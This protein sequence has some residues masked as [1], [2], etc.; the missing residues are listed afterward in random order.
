MK[1]NSVNIPDSTSFKDVKLSNDLS[2]N[3]I[4]IRTIMDNSSDLL[5][6]QLIVSG[7]KCSLVSLEGMVS[8]SMCTELIFRPLA[9]INLAQGSTPEDVFT[10]LQSFNIMSLDRAMSYTFGEL[11]H[12]LMSGFVII[13][14]NGVNSAICLGI[15]GY[16]KRSVSEP[17]TEA[18]LQGSQDGF[19]EVVRTNMSLI[20]RRLK[21]PLLKF[22]LFPL[23]AKSQTDICLVYMT[24]KAPA[25][26]VKQIKGNLSKVDLEII[27]AGGYIEPF[28][29]SNTLS[30]FSGVSTT[31][32]PDVL[33]AKI[34]EG[35]VAVLVDGTPF[36]I[37]VP[38]L[39]IENFQTLD[40]YSNRPFYG[41]YIRWLKYFAVFLAM[42][43]PGLY[44][45][46]ATFHPEM[47]THSLL[48]NLS[49]AQELTPFNLTIE[50]VIVILLYE[51]IREAGIRMPKV[52]GSAVGIVGGLVIGDAAVSSGLI[53]TPLL[54]IL[55]LTATSSFV[56]PNL[57]QQVSVL[58]F[59]FIFAGGYLGLYG[60]A[61]LT[62]LVLF[63]ICSMETFG[64]P[65]TAPLAP[66]TLKAMK[67]V[68]IR[69]SFKTLEKDA[70]I[71]E[72]LKGVTSYKD[73]K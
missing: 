49:A 12:F 19:V 47:F 70:T 26:L 34:N 25:K 7:H 3:L 13:L 10:Q 65:Y 4:N 48:L 8:T 11:I 68:L 60:V 18:N 39:F 51:I 32:R 58:R 38:T 23:G 64:I 59:L 62:A 24:D 67:D 33:C 5:I 31:Q 61:L 73:S 56:I 37:I 6:N 17:T 1:N 42:V 63:N 71:I 72:N 27:L 66:F 50:A 43:L 14:V 36:A 28:L 20:R 40:D 35:R 57:N 53:S 2:E 44:V 16:E 55:G 52:V 9:N 46:I 15:Q 45:A 30:I 21:T 41:T 22:E 54:I 69:M 29:E